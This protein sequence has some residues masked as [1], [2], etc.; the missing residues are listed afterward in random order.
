MFATGE[1][2]PPAIQKAISTRY[3]S[4]KEKSNHQDTKICFQLCFLCDFVLKI[5]PTPYPFGFQTGFIL[6]LL[7]TTIPI[8][9]PKMAPAMNSENQ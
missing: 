7:P 6:K 1:A 5:C 9:L 2:R 8:T 4:Q 3:G